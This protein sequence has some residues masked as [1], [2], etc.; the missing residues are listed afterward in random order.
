MSDKVDILAFG[1]H[2]DDVE[3]SCS[4]TIISHIAAG[5][6]VAVVDL[7]EGELGTR[8]SAET[9]KKES[10]AASSIM[11]IHYRENLG[12]K[13]GFFMNDEAHQL[14]VIEMIR[15]FR[16]EIVLCNALH[17]RHPDHGRGSRLVSDS[18]FLS[19]LVKIKGENQ[20]PWKPRAVYH[21]IQDR[22]IQPSFVID[23]SGFIQQKMDCIK[24]YSTQFYDPSSKEPETYISSPAFL[25]SIVSRNA[26]FGRL[27][28]VEHAEGFTA[29]RLFGVKDM[30]SII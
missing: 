23:I 16:P 5:F 12:F 15:K 6:R 1:S 20:A 29:E 25:T 11:R 3:L 19:G 9:R 21:Y 4:G 28:G 7:T 2:P 26:E 10:E 13:D 22:Y 30:L 27:I 14:K 18:C 17:D 8:G 24:A